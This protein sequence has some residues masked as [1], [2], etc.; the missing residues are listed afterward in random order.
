MCGGEALKIVEFDRKGRLLGS[1][2][3]VRGDSRTDIE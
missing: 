1:N 2:N 3:Q